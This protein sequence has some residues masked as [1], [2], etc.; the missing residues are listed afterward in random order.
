MKMT[1]GIH[2]DKEIEV[3]PSDY[4]EWVAKTWKENTQE[5]K[6]ICEAADIEFQFRAKHN[7][8]F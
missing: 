5:N 8:H 4:L 6:D 3:I 1:C 2:K 7:S